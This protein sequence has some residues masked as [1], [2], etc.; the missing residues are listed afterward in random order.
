MKTQ[1]LLIIEDEERIRKLVK[2]YAVMDGFALDEAADGKSGLKMALEGD[3]AVVI[4]DIMLPGIDGWTICREIRAEIPVPIIILTARGEEYDKLHG[5]ELGADDYIVK[6]FSP[7]E[8][9]A[10]VRV[11]IKRANPA[12]AGK[13]EQ[14]EFGTIKI[15]G[16]ARQVFVGGDEK[17]L[18]PKEFD[19]L[20]FLAQNPKQVFS[21]DQLMNSVWGYDFFG[22]ARTVDTHIKQ[23]REKIGD[24]GHDFIKTVWGKGYM[25]IAGESK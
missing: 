8:L 10:R 25:F 23:L 11:L 14:I 16:T 6:P 22:D 17:A 9:M 4:V 1:R 24:A 20:L 2:T 15:D 18:T 19:L 12:S 13:S 7:K 5:F 21:R 3:Y